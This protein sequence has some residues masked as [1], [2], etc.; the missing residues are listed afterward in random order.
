MGWCDSSVQ[1]TIAVEIRPSRILSSHFWR[2]QTGIGTTL[3]QNLGGTARATPDY[4]AGCLGTLGFPERLGFGK[5]RILQLG[6]RVVCHLSTG[7][8][9]PSGADWSKLR[10]QSRFDDWS[11]GFLKQ[12][13]LGAHSSYQP[14]TNGLGRPNRGELR[15]VGS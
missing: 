2:G 9:L 8:L 13:S 10:D 14:L 6:L 3:F 5:V 11:S 4:S 1:S 12:V 15:S 7:R